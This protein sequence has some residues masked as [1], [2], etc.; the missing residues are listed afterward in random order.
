MGNEYSIE[1]IDTRTIIGDSNN[2][3]P[4]ILVHSSNNITY[5]WL[6]FLLIGDQMLLKQVSI[7]IYSLYIPVIISDSE[8]DNN[9]YNEKEFL[10]AKEKQNPRLNNF[11]NMVTNLLIESIETWIN[12]S[13]S[14]NDLYD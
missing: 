11:I 1:L 12:N 3:L 5:P 8:I 4:A 10:I 2:V 6:G 7:S 14:N 9:K 13:N